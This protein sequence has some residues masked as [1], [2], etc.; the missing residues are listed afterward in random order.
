MELEVVQEALALIAAAPPDATRA[1]AKAYD[2]LPLSEKLSVMSRARGLV[3]ARFGNAGMNLMIDGSARAARTAS[4]AAGFTDHYDYRRVEIATEIT[5]SALLVRANLKAAE[6]EMLV[7]PWGEYLGSDWTDTGECASDPLEVPKQ[8]S[9]ETVR[10]RRAREKKE[11]SDEKK[12]LKEE[13]SAE[14]AKAK[15]AKRGKKTVAPID[16]VAAITGEVAP[17]PP[18]VHTAETLDEIVLSVA[19][20]DPKSWF[21]GECRIMWWKRDSCWKIIAPA[22][23]KATVVPTHFDSQELAQQYADGQGWTVTGVVVPRERS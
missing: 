6:F 11:A 8:V 23:S 13:A 2:A 21:S 7:K 10:E 9:M 19:T 18:P 14:K 12:R 20:E 1:A 15:Y 17:E 5:C 3:F 4:K 16:L 22:P